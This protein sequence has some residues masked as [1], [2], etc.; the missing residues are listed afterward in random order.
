MAT[1]YDLE[2]FAPEDI[3]KARKII[4][5]LCR[6][7]KSFRMSIPPHRDDSDMLLSRCIHRL[8]DSEFKLDVLKEE[9]EMLWSVI[10]SIASF[11]DDIKEKLNRV[12]REK[13]LDVWSTEKAD[14]FPDKFTQCPELKLS[15]SFREGKSR[16]G[17]VNTGGFTPKPDVKPG[18]SEINRDNPPKGSALPGA[19]IIIKK[20]P[21]KRSII[22]RLFDTR[23]KASQASRKFDFD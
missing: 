5:N 11:S 7:P 12:Q 22:E 18:A 19:E 15:P 16:K 21:P 17:G 3:Q 1:K 8:E 6:S 13:G 20:A 10:R 23:S 4:S 9:N 14:H 2:R